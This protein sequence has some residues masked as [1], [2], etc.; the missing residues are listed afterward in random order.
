[1]WAGLSYN[2]SVVITLTVPGSLFSIAIECSAALTTWCIAFLWQLLH[3]K[4]GSDPNSCYS[5]LPSSP[6][7]TLTRCWGAA[8]TLTPGRNFNRTEN[9]RTRISQFW[10]R[11]PRCVL[12]AASSGTTAHQPHVQ[13]ASDVIHERLAST[14][15]ST[16]A[17]YHPP[18]RAYWASW[19][20]PQNTLCHR[21]QRI[22][23]RP[24]SPTPVTLPLTV[25]P[26]WFSDTFLSL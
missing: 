5:S 16:F 1:M 15:S 20:Q 13:K 11:W 3:L 19:A 22:R 12:T 24:D 8:A 2:L 14:S 21:I 18:S 10:S 4:A 25:R 17:S 23:H 7:W 9:L 6:P 26:Q